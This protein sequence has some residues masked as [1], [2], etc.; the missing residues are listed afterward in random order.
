MG[1]GSFLPLPAPGVP[2]VPGLW[3][4]PSSPCPHRH[5][6]IFFLPVSSSHKDTSGWNTRCCSVA[7]S[8]LTLKPHGLQHSRLPCPS[9][10]LGSGSNL[11]PLSQ[12]CHPTISSCHPLLLLHSIFPSIRVFSSELMLHIRWWKYWSFNVSISPSNEY[13]GLISFRVDWFEVLA[14]QGTLK[15]LLQHYSS[16]TSS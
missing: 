9:L 11:C 5:M 2:G 6:A 1:A 14:V 15:S 3:L 13:L 16:K 7:K 10:S 12:Q 8:C 4:P